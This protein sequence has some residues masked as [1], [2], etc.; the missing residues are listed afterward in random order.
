[1]DK[2]VNTPNRPP[3]DGECERIDQ[4]RYICYSIDSS[5]ISHN[6]M[7]I[8]HAGETVPCPKWS[9]E[10]P[11]NYWKN[12]GGVYVIE[13]VL[14]GRG[15]I[16]CDDKVYTVEAGDFYMLTRFHAHK[17]YSDPEYPCR[18]I[19]V[20]LSGPFV[21]GLAE[22][23]GL[24]DGVYIM[25]GDSPKRIRQIH[26][27][28][29]SFDT[30]PQEH[31]FDNIAMILTDIFLSVNLSRKS[32]GIHNSNP[33][34]EMKRYIDSE[35]NIGAN[36]DDICQQFKVSKSYAIASFRKTYGITL[37]Q[38]M[39]DQKVRSAKAMIR[40][41]V[42]LSSVASILGYSC[43]QSFT[44]AFKKA[45]GLSPTEYKDSVVQLEE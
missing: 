16:E 32:T 26:A 9:F 21:V 38:Y 29:N 25:H 28:L 3:L 41:G 6:G 27:L 14:E 43:T 37:Y 19:W 20:N 39:L 15:Y 18:K 17:Y 44:H 1:M 33:I 24:S 12:K 2:N 30:L 35:V 40:N 45:T 34:A 22:G 5:R 10:R 4:S 31:I 11:Q 7:Y 8:L 23:L 13:H 42:K 36:L